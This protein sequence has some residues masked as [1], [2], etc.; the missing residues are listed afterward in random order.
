MMDDVL[1]LTLF[2]ML[3]RRSGA[4]LEIG[5]FLAVLLFL[6]DDKVVSILKTKDS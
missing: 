3:P 4:L 6:R 2:G 1:A 5:S